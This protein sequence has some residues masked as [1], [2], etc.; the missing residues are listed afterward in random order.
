MLGPRLG[1]ARGVA[2][3]P[4][5]LED[6]R[7]YG[8]WA[9]RPEVTY[10]WGIRAGKWNPASRDEHYREIAKDDRSIN[11]S[12]QLDGRT[13]G[14]TGIDFIDW[15]RR[16]GESYIIVGDHRVWGRGVA[17]EAVRLRTRFA[18]RELNLHRVYNLIVYDNV[19]SRRAN[20]KVGYREQGRMPGSFR[21][22]TQRHDDWLGEILRSDWEACERADEKK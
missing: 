8:D 16:Q 22:G 20:E 13:V 2:L 10:F 9:A 14:F 7:L 11:W 18:F 5:T 3:V 17:S 1:G 6:H 12:I 15:I 21:R 19:G 4:R